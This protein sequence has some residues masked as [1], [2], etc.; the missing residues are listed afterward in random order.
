MLRS[1]YD[2]TVDV[3]FGDFGRDFTAADGSRYLIVVL[4]S[5]HWQAFMQATGLTNVA[6]ALEATLPADFRRARDRYTHREALSAIAADDAAI[7]RSDPLMSEIDQPGIGRH[8]APGGPLVLNGLQ[9]PPSP[10]PLLGQHTDEV[11]EELLSLTPSQL[12]DL[13]SRRVVGE[14]E[15]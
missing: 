10:A 4:N 3:L 1:A 15:T 14:P 8:L 5:R 6:A 12:G 7:M 11:L 9:T 2:P 13:R